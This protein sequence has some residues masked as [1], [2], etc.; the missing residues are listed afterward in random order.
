MGHRA[1]VCLTSQERSVYSTSRVFIM[2]SY[3]SSGSTGS[4]FLDFLYLVGLVISLW[5]AVGSGAHAF[6]YIDVDGKG[7]RLVLG[8]VVIAQDWHVSCCLKAPRSMQ[9]I[10]C[11]RCCG[12]SCFAKPASLRCDYFQ[13]SAVSP[14]TYIVGFEDLC[15]W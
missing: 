9:S 7:L 1:V 10:L 15:W 14:L 11:L 13:G 6:H 8:A 5:R 12:L 4:S 2:L 3:T